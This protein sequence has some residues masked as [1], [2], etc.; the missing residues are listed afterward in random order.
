[1]LLQVDVPTIA[2]GI[3]IS[4]TTALI[5]YAFKL[6]STIIELKRELNFLTQ[7][8]R[9]L[10]ENYKSLMHEVHR[11]RDLIMVMKGQTGGQ[12]EEML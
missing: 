11:L 2:D 1:M 3:L 4:S 9:E 12:H 5:F 7:L 10:Q 6:N 8:H